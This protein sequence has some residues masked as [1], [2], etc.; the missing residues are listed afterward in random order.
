MLQRPIALAQVPDLLLCERFDLGIGSGIVQQRLTVGERAD[1]VLVGTNSANDRRELGRVD[2]VILAIGPF[3][4]IA[5]LLQL[6][7]QREAVRQLQQPVEGVERLR[8][9]LIRE[10]GRILWRLGGKNNE[11]T[12][13]ND[14]ER[15]SQQHSIRRIPNG[16]VMLFDNGNYHAVPHS[17]AVEY[18]LDENAKGR[19]AYLEF[20]CTHHPVHGGW[21]RPGAGH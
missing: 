1:R 9:A 14:P 6:A 11:F 19:P 4:L 12:F 3:S 16:H 2:G 13:V 8:R 5:Q 15:F 10:D 21:V 18:A 20:I 17:R 7:L